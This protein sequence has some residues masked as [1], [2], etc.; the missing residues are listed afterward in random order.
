ML[1]AS[2][3]S[4]T[5]KLVNMVLPLLLAVRTWWAGEWGGQM[6]GETFEQHKAKHSSEPIARVGCG[7]PELR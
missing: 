3:S 4:F 1:K 6:V 5:W 7:R 2:S